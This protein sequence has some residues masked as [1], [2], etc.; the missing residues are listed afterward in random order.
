MK[1]DCSPASTSDPMALFSGVVY[2]GQAFAPINNIK[3]MISR[4]NYSSE[5]DRF[6]VLPNASDWL[7]GSDKFVMMALWRLGAREQRF[8][9]LPDPDLACFASRIERCLSTVR[10]MQQ[11]TRSR[12]PVVSIDGKVSLGYARSVSI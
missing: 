5:I 3:S 2:V 6:P 4:S 12:Y 7:W 11:T 9:H 1:C 10:S 8:V